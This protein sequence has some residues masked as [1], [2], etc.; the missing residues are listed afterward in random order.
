MNRE[1]AIRDR[2]A[3]ATPGKWLTGN[4]YTSH[5]DEVYQYVSQQGGM[6]RRICRVD[7]NGGPLESPNALLIANAPDDLN[8]LLAELDALRAQ[9]KGDEG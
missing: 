4:G 3:K 8:Y 2:L 7:A 9:L 1:E 6:V 5:A